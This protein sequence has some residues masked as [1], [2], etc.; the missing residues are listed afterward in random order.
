MTYKQ[1]C[2]TIFQLYLYSDS[3]KMVHYTT[4]SNHG[5]ELADKIRDSII[6]IADN[7]AEM[8]FGFYG[9]PKFSDLTLKQE[10]YEEN[11]LTKI[12]QHAVDI[13][14]PIRTDCEENAKLSGIVSK[15][16]D[17]KAQMSQYSF[18]GTFDKV[19][20]TLLKK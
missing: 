10:V 1:V 18:L 13:L 7:V 15:I 5:H 16:D 6:D 4:D 11:D 9:K 2:D 19:S 14:E 20:N 8:Y 17:F 12:C 3:A